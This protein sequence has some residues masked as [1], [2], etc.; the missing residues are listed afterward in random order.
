MNNVNLVTITQLGSFNA[1]DFNEKLLGYKQ[2]TA[3]T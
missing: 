2:S 1:K 3:K